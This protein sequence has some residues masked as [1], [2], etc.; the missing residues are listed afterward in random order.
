[1]AAAQTGENGDGFEQSFSLFSEW[2]LNNNAEQQ[3]GAQRGAAG[4][5]GPSHPRPEDDGDEGTADEM[6]KPSQRQGKRPR[7]AAQGED[8][9]GSGK[10]RLPPTLYLSVLVSGT[11][12]MP[13]SA[14]TEAGR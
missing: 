8:G 5:P 9:G 12:L 6:P 10:A 2:A 1:M 11:C 4:P 7:K 3:N 13:G 14:P